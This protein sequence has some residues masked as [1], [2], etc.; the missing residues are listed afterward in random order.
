MAACRIRPALDPIERDLADELRSKE[1]HAVSLPADHRLCPPGR[2]CRR[3]S[4]ALQ[5]TQPL[6]ELAPLLR[7]EGRRVTHVVK[8]SVVVVQPEE[9]GPDAVVVLGDAVPADH[10]VRGLPMLHLHP[11]AGAPQV[12]LVGAL[13]DDAVLAEPASS[14]NHSLAAATSSVHGVRR[15]SGPGSR[16]SRSCGA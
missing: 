15:R 1:T 9:Q 4:F 8:G 11:P 3:S 14:A 16:S 2:A 13:G 10:A 6:P 7:L 5:R 12:R